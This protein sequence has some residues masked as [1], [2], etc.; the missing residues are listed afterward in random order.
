MTAR[1]YGL[2]ASSTQA[3]PEAQPADTVIEEEPAETDD[4]PA[5]ETTTQPKVIP[6]LPNTCCGCRGVNE[7]L[8][9]IVESQDVDVPVR[10]RLT[11]IG[12]S[13]L[14]TG[15]S[16]VTIGA[17]ENP[18]TATGGVMVVARQHGDEPAGTRAALEMIRRFAFDDGEKMSALLGG[19][20]VRI[21]PVANPD[22]MDSFER[23]TANGRD[24]NRD[25]AALALPETRAVAKAIRQFKPD[26]LVDL[27]ELTPQDKDSS[28]VVCIPPA[29]VS[30]LVH[31]L[32]SAF[33]RQGSMVST[34]TRERY[35]ATQLLHRH[36]ASIY[37]RPALL[38][39]SRYTGDPACNL[40]GRS[41]YHQTAITAVLESI[42][43]PSE[44]PA[45]SVSGQ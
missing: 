13:Q 10:I 34:R 18:D 23:Q 44:R 35:R 26:V 7:F 22:G 5:T 4:Q 45:A 2:P 9:E 38:V 24:M 40:K 21:I 30:K 14:G 36:F 15:I 16:M 41:D 28:H 19:K 33:E 25:W 37:G 31:A 3:T 8:R 12:C 43:E 29:K 11:E 1:V 39:E 32:R 27:H 6:E 17:W 42:S 20:M